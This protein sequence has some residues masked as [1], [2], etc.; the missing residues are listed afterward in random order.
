MWRKFFKLYKKYFYL[1][2]HEFFYFKNIV[3]IDSQQNTAQL[4][5]PAEPDQPAK[6][7]AFDGAYG[8]D[9]NTETIYGDVGFPLVESVRKKFK[10]KN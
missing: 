2:N 10:K 1:I 7:F 4:I 3:K 6:S 5:C 8:I 9:S